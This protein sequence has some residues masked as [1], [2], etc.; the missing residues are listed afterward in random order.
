MNRLVLAM[1]F[2]YRKFVS[3]FKG[4]SCAYRLHTGGLSCSAHGYRVIE[5]HGISCGLKLIGRRLD[6][7]RQKYLQFNTVRGGYKKTLKARLRAHFA[8]S[9]N[10]CT[11]LYSPICF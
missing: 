7:C 3:P 5:R 11:F 1:I 8:S 4:F 2:L 10:F 9:K 6:R